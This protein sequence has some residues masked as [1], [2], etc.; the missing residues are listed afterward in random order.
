VITALSRNAPRDR[1][2]VVR[3][4]DTTKTTLRYG[5]E[6]GTSIAAPIVAGI[7]ALMLQADPALTPEK[8]KTILTETAIHD[9]HTGPLTEK[10]N[11]WGA[12][13]V[14]A[15][16]A[17]A[18]LLGISVT[19]TQK[20]RTAKTPSVR[21]THGRLLFSSVSSP[22]MSVELYDMK[23]R[24]VLR[25]NDGAVSN[26]AFSAAIA[27]GIYSTRARLIDGSTIGPIRIA[28]VR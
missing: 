2:E 18:Q 3:W 14:N 12:G 8:V 28:V 19:R 21:F 22:V 4:P 23:G 25:L 9:D 26:A 17:M 27:T 13:K 24:M 10:S 7:I 20:E 1:P 15:W 11:W 5:A 16:G 6:T